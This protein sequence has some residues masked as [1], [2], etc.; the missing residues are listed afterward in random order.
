MTRRGVDS[1]QR[2]AKW[3]RAEARGDPVAAGRK[4]TAVQVESSAFARLGGDSTQD[5][6]A[7]GLVDL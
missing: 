2:V 1:A 5:L 7:K 4:F 6:G 3:K